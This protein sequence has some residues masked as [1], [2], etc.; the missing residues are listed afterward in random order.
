MIKLSVLLNSVQSVMRKTHS[1]NNI[2]NFTW[3]VGIITQLG[4]IID[5][6]SDFDNSAI[7]QQYIFN[8]SYAIA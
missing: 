7:F 6:E 5:F 4:D 8:N 2:Q 1:C 3:M